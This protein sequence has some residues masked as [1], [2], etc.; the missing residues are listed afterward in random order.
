MACA[1]T[2]WKGSFQAAADPKGR[3]SAIATG[4]LQIPRRAKNHPEDSGKVMNVLAM[5]ASY[6]PDPTQ[7]IR[8]PVTIDT[9]ELIEARWA[10]WPRQDPVTAIESRADNLREPKALY[11]DCSDSSTRS[12]APAGSY[13]G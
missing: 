4:A 7:F 10:N 12:T 5:A 9:Y 1:Q 13:D 3:F 2:R 11:T 8:L 6:D